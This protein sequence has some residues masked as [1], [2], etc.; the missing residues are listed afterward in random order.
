MDEHEVIDRQPAV[1]R[2]RVEWGSHKTHC[3]HGHEYAI[4]RLRRYVSRGKG[5]PR[6]ASKQ[7]LACAHEQARARRA[8]SQ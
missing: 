4:G 8:K 7:C 1:A 5:V 3:V 2:G 6:R